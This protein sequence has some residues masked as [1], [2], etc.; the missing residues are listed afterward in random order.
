MK[1]LKGF[2]L[3]VV[4]I[5]MLGTGFMAQA[6]SSKQTIST[7]DI[8]AF[9]NNVCKILGQN[10]GSV[11]CTTIVGD[12]EKIAGPG[13]TNCAAVCRQIAT[14]CKQ[15]SVY[16]NFNLTPNS[17]Q[18]NGS[19]CKCQVPGTKNAVIMSFSEEN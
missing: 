8:I 15:K 6:K 5:T 10:A 9:D 14:T 13:G 17:E 1:L 11:T 12:K 4:M 16:S 7:C 19:I 3:S 2:G 18:K